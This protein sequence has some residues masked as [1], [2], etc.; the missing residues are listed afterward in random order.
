MSKHHKAEPVETHEAEPTVLAVASDGIRRGS[1]D[2]VEAASK[3]W[4]S[5][6]RFASRF[7]YTTCYTISYGVVFP[8]MLAAG[9][10]PRENAA[11]R[12]LMDG[13]C[14]G[15]AAADALTSPHGEPAALPA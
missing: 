1:A 3:A 12:G 6:G 15:R 8:V 2:A 10:V 11:V 5:A 9:S 13:A 14:D 7:V 4:E